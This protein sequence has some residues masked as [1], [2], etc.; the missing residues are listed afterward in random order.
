M[1]LSLAINLWNTGQWI[2]MRLADE[3]SISCPTNTSSNEQLVFGTYAPKA[4][5]KLWLYVHPNDRTDNY[6]IQN[7]RTEPGGLWS[8]PV[9]LGNRCWRNMIDKSP[10]KYDVFVGLSKLGTKLPGTDATPLQVA[11][12]VD[13]AQKLLAEG[14]TAVTHCAITRHTKP[15]CSSIPRILQPVVPT[16]PCENVTVDGEFELRWEPARKLWVELWLGGHE[17]P[18]YSHAFRQSGTRFQLESGLYQVKVKENQQSRCDASLWID[19]VK[20]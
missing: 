20:R 9:R 19:V 1:L 4:N 10:L 17:V 11:S 3:V 6:W 15:V 8:F 18:G 12:G 2:K 5:R 13:F 14:A 16:D 7:I